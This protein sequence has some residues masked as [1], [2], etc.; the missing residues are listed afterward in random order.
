MPSQMMCTRVFDVRINV[1][2]QRDQQ[3]ST[4]FYFSLYFDFIEAKQYVL[5]FL[6]KFEL[7]LDLF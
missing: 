6:F 7:P 1:T 2:T 4:D 5:Q 3:V